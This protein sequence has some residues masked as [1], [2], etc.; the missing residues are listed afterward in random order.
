[1]RHPVAVL[2]VS[3]LIAVVHAGAD[4]APSTRVSADGL[5]TELLGGAATGPS[6][7]IRFTIIEAEM[8]RWPAPVTVTIKRSNE[9]K[10][11]TVFLEPRYATKPHVIQT[12][13]GTHEMT[14]SAP[15]YAAVTRTAST[16]KGNVDLGSLTLSRLPV[17]GGM[18]R[19]GDGSPA[20]GAFVDDGI[21]H[22]TKTDATGTYAV[23]VTSGWPARLQISYPGYSTRDVPVS[24][25][26]ASATLPSLTLTKG[27]RV[28]IEF[29]PAEFG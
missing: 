17:L 14:F 1:M 20:V 28:E 25:T 22:T 2:L 26:R 16:I 11:W 13:A 5:S 19:T 8:E 3:L 9:S 12:K 4:E 24:K 27:S 6:R 23:E 10:P 7:T 21:G 29:K 18:V 15:H